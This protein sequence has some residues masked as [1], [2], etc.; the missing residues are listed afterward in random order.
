MVSV[1]SCLRFGLS[2]FALS[3]AVLLLAQESPEPPVAEQSVSDTLPADTPAPFTPLTLGQKYKYSVNQTM[4]LPRVAF[5]SIRAAFDQVNKT[6]QQ[7]GFGAEAY[8]VRFASHMGRSL[9]RE[10]LA[11][12]VRAVDHEDPRYFRSGAGT[13]ASRAKYAVVHTFIV[14]SDSGRW[15]PAYSRFVSS[16]GMPF[17]ARQWR[18]SPIHTLPDGLR[19]GSMGIGIN[20]ASN[21]GQEFLPELKSLRHKLRR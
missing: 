4:T 3:G 5:M 16:Y 21:I 20:I 6:P 8:T 9:V 13:I 18:P 12:S 14:R 15:M 7:W 1:R 2:V 11:F 19:A 17:I 10:S